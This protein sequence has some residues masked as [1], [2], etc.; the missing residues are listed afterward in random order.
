MEHLLSC[1]PPVRIACPVEFPGRHDGSRRGAGGR[2]S[3][4]H[5]AVTRLSVVARRRQTAWFARRAWLG[6]P[7]VVV[8]GHDVRADHR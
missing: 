8:S 3:V 4:K 2:M 1:R 5:V 7:S 6:S